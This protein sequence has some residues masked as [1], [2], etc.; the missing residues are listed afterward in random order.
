MPRLT[1][2]QLPRAKNCGFEILLFAQYILNEQLLITAHIYAS[3]LPNWDIIQ[4]ISLVDST[5]VLNRLDGRYSKK[6]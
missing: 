4:C 5:T 1:Q 6:M 3:V 2:I